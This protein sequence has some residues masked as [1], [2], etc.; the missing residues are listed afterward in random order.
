MQASVLEQNDVVYYHVI[1]WIEKHHVKR[2]S[3][4]Q[5]LS[6]VMCYHKVTSSFSPCFGY[7]Y[8]KHT[9]TYISIHISTES[10]AVSRFELDPSEQDKIRWK[11]LVKTVMNPGVKYKA[12][13]FM[14]TS[15]SVSFSR[16]TR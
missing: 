13:N 4:P 3:V 14:V 15:A 11:A 6:V 8:K 10:N 12:R 5:N 9:S 16:A 2:Q 7:V 1:G